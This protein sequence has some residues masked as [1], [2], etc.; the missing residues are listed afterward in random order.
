[1]RFFLAFLVTFAS[2]LRRLSLN[3]C[4]VETFILGH[5]AP[6]K[7]EGKTFGPE[8]IMPMMDARVSSSTKGAELLSKLP[9]CLQER[10]IPIKFVGP[11]GLQRAVTWLMTLCH[12]KDCVVYTSLRNNKELDRLTNLKVEFV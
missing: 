5:G 8:G 9:P 7:L 1:M 10:A 2:A 3:P 11:A 12:H 4:D 6:T